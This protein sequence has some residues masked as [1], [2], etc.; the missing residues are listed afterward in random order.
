MKLAV[1]SGRSALCSLCGR[2][3]PRKAQSTIPQ[4][5]EAARVQ[6]A[7][8]P[9]GVMESWVLDMFA[10]DTN[11]IAPS[12]EPKWRAPLTG[13]PAYTFP[14]PGISTESA[15][16]SRGFLGPSSVIACAE[17]ARRGTWQWADCAAPARVTAKQ[18]K[19]GILVFNLVSSLRCMQSIVAAQDR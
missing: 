14:K 16:A 6:T 8:Q 19:T 4:T 17:S 5:Y 9:H 15:A 10:A 1:T 18:M 7:S 11:P 13:S 2:R 3:S 12:T